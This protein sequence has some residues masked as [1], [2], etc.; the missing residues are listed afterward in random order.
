MNRTRARSA[1]RHRHSSRSTAQ[2]KPHRGEDLFTGRRRKILL[3]NHGQL[4]D[5]AHR[6]AYRDEV[7]PHLDERQRL[8]EVLVETRADHDDAL[9]DHPR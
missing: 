5:D 4:H 6:D 2:H 7:E 3:R 1:P 9:T 8:L